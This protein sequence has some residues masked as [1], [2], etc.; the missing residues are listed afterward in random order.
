[1][2]GKPAGEVL[3][4][5]V[6][7]SQFVQ[8]T[9]GIGRGYPGNTGCRRDRYVGARVDTQPPEHPRGLA[10]ELPGGPGEYRADAGLG[11]VGV[12]GV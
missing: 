2:E 9:A 11:A 1:M 4:D 5:Q 6:R 12:K 3:G 10:A 8:Q 7:A